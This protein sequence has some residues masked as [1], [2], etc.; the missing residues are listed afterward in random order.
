MYLRY[1]SNQLKN[2]SAETACVACK[3]GCDMPSKLL[4]ASMVFSYS[5]E[6]QSA[7][8]CLKITPALVSSILRVDILQVIYN[9]FIGYPTYY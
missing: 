2:G 6:E 5:E 3:A 7:F 9:D 8:E 1:A 4:S